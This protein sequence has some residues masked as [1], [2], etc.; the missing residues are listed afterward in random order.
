[1][2]KYNLKK[3]VTGILFLLLIFLFAFYNLRTAFTPIADTVKTIQENGNYSVEDKIVTIE[4]T[5]NDNVFDNY[6]FVE[7]YGYMQLLMG[8]DEI[9]N[10]EI[11]RDAKGDKLY[12]TNFASGPSDVTYMAD[13]MRE[14]DKTAKKAGSTLMYLATPD[15]YIEGYT[16]FPAGIPY[17]YAN[18]TVDAFLEELDKS[19]IDYLDYR[20]LLETSGIEMEN[21]FYKTDHHWKIQ[22]SF[23]AFTE[24]LNKLESGYGEIF[25]DREKV[26]DI[27]NYNQITYEDAHVGSQGKKTGLLYSGVDDFTLIYPKYETSYTFYMELLDTSTTLDGRMEDCLIGNSILNY[28]GKDIYNMNNDRYYSYLYGNQGYV[29]IENEDNEDGIKALFI[30]DSMIPPVATFFTQTCSTVD[31]IDPRYYQGDIDQFVA[32]GDFDYIFVSFDPQ[33]LTPEFF[34]FGNIDK[35]NENSVT[36]EIALEREE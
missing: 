14:L 1:M 24:L 7:G 31:L 27:N 11:V 35:E 4:N 30:K 3:Y 17:N 2:N 34:P 18:E 10:F 16:T 21:L 32:N 33:N 23:W 29:H 15:K 20:D 36:G 6:L 12:Y 25:P 13:S 5:I 22:T 28:E 19:K 26:T 9:N 8:K